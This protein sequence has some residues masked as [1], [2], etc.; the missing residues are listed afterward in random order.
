MFHS[1][2]R[3]ARPGLVALAA[4]TVAT[5]PAMTPAGAADADA[6]A[7]DST[8]GGSSSDNSNLATVVVTARRLNEARAE[9]QTQTGASTYT[10]D[11]TAIAATPGG[12]NVQLNQ[13]LLQAPDVVQDSFG[14]LHVRADHNDLQY[15]I[16][17]IILPEGISVFSQ[18]LSPRL[19][20]SLSL[21]TGALP[22]EYGLRTAGIVDL[23]TNSGLLQPGGYASVY[24]GSFGTFQPAAEYGGSSGNFSYYVTGDYKQDNLGIESPDG[25]T[26][27]LH[28]HTTQV[29]AFGYFEEIIDTTNRLSLI[30]G[31]SDDSFQ[32]PNQRGLQPTLGLDVQG[33]SQFLSNNLNETQHEAAQYAIVSWQHSE[34]PLNWQSSLS[35]RYTTLHFAPDWVGDLLYNGIAQN[36]FKDDTALGWQTDGAYK[37][38]AAHTVRA[39]AY[40]QHDSAESDTT[41]QVLP[42]NALGVPTSDIPLTVPDNGKQSQ[43]IESVYVQDEWQVLAPLTINY[44]LRFDHYSAYSSGSQLSP[45]VNIVWKLDTGTTVHGGYSR[46]YTPPPFELIGT[47]TFAKFAGTTALP[48]GTITADTAPLAERANYYDLGV[49]Q[50]LLDN[51]LTLGADSFYEQAQ[52]L[53]DEGQFG[54]PIILTPFNYRYGLIGGVEF[55]ANY[56]VSNFSAYG[57]LSFQAAHGKDVESS[58]F[59]FSAGDLA[60]IA[61][62]YIHLDHEGRVAASGGVSYLWMGTRFSTDMLFGTG[63]RDALVLPNGTSIPNGDHTPSY[64]QVNL[65]LS[66]EFRLPS[67]GP[68]SVR[69]DVINLFDKVYAIRNGTGIGVFAP[70]YG[71]RRG[72]FGGV[73]WQF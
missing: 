58:Q 54:A 57:N 19:I 67:T 14:Q 49:Q 27:P 33:I 68:L 46:Y 10:I 11:S 31:S 63:L 26:D 41:S 2:S 18:T 21:I 64:T 66:H 4:F 71:T 12:E 60:Y 50:K 48:P 38:N 15:R 3:G 53:I 6:A 23:T 51:T 55:T 28:D 13:V 65:G 59:N 8:A 5:L 20:S 22:A 44:G 24:G 56:S 16:N 45:R 40:F 69:F 36:A 37:V 47:E 43:S 72:L 1:R 42:I 17:G 73:S 35:A 25:S 30:L 7:T 52:H 61:D 62:N 29:H 32:I 9:I 70:Q 34:G 39:G